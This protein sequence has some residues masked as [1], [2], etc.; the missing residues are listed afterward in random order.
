MI[1]SCKALTAA[2]AAP[3]STTMLMDTSDEPWAI[4]LTLMPL[5]PS[6]WNNLPDTPGVYLFRGKGR[7]ILYIGKAAS[8]RDRVRSYFSPELIKDV[9]DGRHVDH[10][11]SLPGGHMEITKN[12][13]LYMN[14]IDKI[15]TKDELAKLK[16]S[17][18]AKI[19][20]SSV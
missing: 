1:N 5:R 11:V 3:G 8:L 19:A 12:P 6:A 10:F 15:L 9:V 2:S 14:E 16:D 13:E 4:A 17:A 20:N 18:D 7:K